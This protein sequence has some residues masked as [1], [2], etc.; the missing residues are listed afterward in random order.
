MIKKTYSKDG[1]VCR[2]RFELPATVTAGTA[3]L[4]GD[5]EDGEMTAQEM[6]PLKSGGFSVTVS[7]PVGH[8][9]RFHYLLDGSRWMNDPSDD[10]FMPDVFG[11]EE[12]IVKV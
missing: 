9:Y 4:Y 1:R 3:F 11:M 7:L 6:K 8:S 5:F 2:V 10:M 12:L